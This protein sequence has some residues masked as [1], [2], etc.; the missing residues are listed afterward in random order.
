VLK[1]FIPRFQISYGLNVI[2]LPAMPSSVISTRHASS[3]CIGRCSSCQTSRHTR[4]SLGVHE[5][6]FAKL[7]TLPSLAKALT[8]SP[9]DVMLVQYLSELLAFFVAQHGHRAQFFILSNPVSMRIASLL[10]MKQ[11][12]LRHGKCIRNTSPSADT[13]PAA[14]QLRSGT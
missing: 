10:Y 3:T 11:K 6:I 8:L 5:R 2:K 9:S 4:V 7:I 1:R 14:R 13:Y 12:P